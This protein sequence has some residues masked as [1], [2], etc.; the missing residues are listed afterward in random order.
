MA[1]SAKKVLVHTCC[2][3]CA[4]YLDMELEKE[5]LEVIFLFCN[6]NLNHL[7]YHH[8]LVGLRG[9]SQI[10]NRELVLPEYDQ[11][12]YFNL[13]S[14]YQD[15]NSIK[16]I[17]DRERLARRG[18]ELLIN[19]LMDFTAKSAAQS[20]IKLITTAMLCSPYRDHNTTWDTGS[21]IARQY[22]LD[23]VYKDFRKGYWMGRNFARK[24]N[25]TIPVYCSDY[26]E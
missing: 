7:E 21:K 22:G 20:K 2:A 18:R 8:R 16:F 25:L 11:E 10:R 5:G 15:S 12:T 24:N 19:L 1:E 3:S 26:M 13:I 6:P 23:F 9:L 17:N 4:S 14:P